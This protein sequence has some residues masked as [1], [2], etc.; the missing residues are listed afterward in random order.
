MAEP[1]HNASDIITYI[2]V[3]LAVLGVLPILWNTVATLASLS[4]IKQILR[5]SK[6]TALTRSDVVNRIIE[7]ELPR[8]AVRPMDRYSDRD[9]YWTL[10]RN[11]SSIPGGTWT[12]FNWR[13]NII[14]HNTQRVEYADQLRQPQVEVAFDDLVCYL[15][16]LGAVPDPQGWRLLRASGLWAPV[17][18]ALMKSPDGREKALT[19]APLDGSDGHLSLKVVWTEPWITRDDSYLPPYWVRLPPSPRRRT[20]PSEEEGE[21]AEPEEDS[22][23]AK[24]EEKAPSS[25]EEDSSSSSIQK[26][27][28]DSARQQ[29]L[30]HSR[31]PITCQIST[32]G[33]ATALSQ[34]DHLQQSLTDL[35]SAPLY[36]EHIRLR[37]PSG[38]SD[39]AWFASA[40]TAYG[41]TSQTI[42]WNYKI[43]D[44]I[45]AFAR[46]ETVPCGVLVL[47]GVVDESATPEWATRHGDDQGR[48]L[49]QFARRTREQRAA[50]EAEAR[51]A[52]AQ[53]AA[54]VRERVMRENEQRVQDMRD[55]MRL[56]A[57]RRETRMMEA[58]QSPKW[59]TGLVA[60]RN[61]AW[62]RKAGEV[63]DELNLKEVV[64]TV[65]HRMVLDGEF[66]SRLCRM[67]DLWKAWA[68]NGGMRRS[69][70]T[71][72][73]EDQMTFAYATLLV[74]IIKDT[75][76]A[77]E[78]TV[79][80]D[81]QECL[82]MWRTVRLG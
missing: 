38:R 31:H 23:P 30:S 17:G 48:Q 28:L 24:G 1:E 34:A 55:R 27:S 15:L 76:M 77:L 52:P 42:L 71:A 4:K 67:L 69:D 11:P 82:R 68:E 5:H 44:D 45:L 65:L 70:L 10:S 8:Y 20:P 13:S 53:K 64:G 43:P 26:P 80:M 29:S 81:L 41:T 18:S 62:M 6:L 14:G 3:P 75:S 7:V 49:D 47:L 32:D 21:A 54:A 25:A 51:M 58:M 40:A 50:M 2:G 56:D 9:D 63:H 35:S 37:S 74:A 57:Q 39:G 22:K 61:L 79:S 33:I 60:E 66:S 12:T 19:I 59:D 72:L 16:D 46:K 73:Q 78:G 36:I